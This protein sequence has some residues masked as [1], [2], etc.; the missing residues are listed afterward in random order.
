MQ[1]SPIPFKG[2]KK[3][4]PNVEITAPSDEEE[5]RE[6]KAIPDKLYDTLNDFK[7]LRD[8]FRNPLR[9][10]SAERSRTGQFGEKVDF[11]EDIDLKNKQT[12]ID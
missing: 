12:L 2:F 7:K 11:I 3:V 1:M 4:A 10:P 8:S 5:P 9:V 6:E